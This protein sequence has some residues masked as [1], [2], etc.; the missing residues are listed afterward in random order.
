MPETDAEQEQRRNHG[1]IAEGRAQHRVRQARTTSACTITACGRRHAAAERPQQQARGR[2]APRTPARRPRRRP[3]R[4]RAWRH[5]HV[6]RSSTTCWLLVRDVHERRDDRGAD[7]E[8]ADARRRAPTSRAAAS[9]RPKSSRE[10][11]ALARGRRTRCTTNQVP[12]CPKRRQRGGER[13]DV[14]RRCRR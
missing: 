4:P 1:E 2:A 3:R 8:Q 12:N 11:P 14:V 13:A 10:R 6:S 9:V 7:E 5:S